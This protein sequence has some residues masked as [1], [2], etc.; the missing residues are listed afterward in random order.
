MPTSF[1]EERANECK[2]LVTEIVT[3][4]D[5]LNQKET[6]FILDMA[7]RLDRYGEKTFISDSQYKWIQA[8]YER[9]C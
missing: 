1:N 5:E 6:Q 3:F 4:M 9:V 2:T 8:I 7:E